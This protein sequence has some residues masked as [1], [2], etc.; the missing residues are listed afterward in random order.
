MIIFFKY[1]LVVVL[2]KSNVRSMDMLVPYKQV[3]MV[4]KRCGCVRYYIVAAIGLS[5]TEMP[6]QSKPRQT[7]PTAR[8]SQIIAA[9]CPFQ[10]C[11]K[12]KLSR[13]ETSG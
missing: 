9:S 11:H 6:C 12:T 10:R 4:C 3:P 1:S 7:P 8:K 5:S 2:G 13:F